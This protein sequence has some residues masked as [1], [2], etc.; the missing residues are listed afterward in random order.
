MGGPFD[1]KGR[2]VFQPFGAGRQGRYFEEKGFL[3]KLK[4]IE[5]FI[6]ADITKF[7][8]VPIYVVPVDNVIRWYHAGDI[9][10]NAKVSR[11]KFCREH[12]N[13]IRFS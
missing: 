12:L 8:N 1:Y 3:A 4:A 9:G 10:I 13:D 6:L 5:G 11:A 2:S 7:P